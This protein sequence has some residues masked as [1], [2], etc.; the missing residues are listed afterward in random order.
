MFKY[1]C[2]LMCTTENSVE[3]GKTLKINKQQCRVVWMPG[4]GITPSQC[5]GK[6]TAICQGCLLFVSCPS[7]PGDMCQQC[8]GCAVLRGSLRPLAPG[9]A[10]QVGSGSALGWAHCVLT[11]AAAFP[12]LLCWAI[13]SQRHVPLMFPPAAACICTCCSCG[14][15]VKSSCS[16]LSLSLV[17]Q[18]G[19]SCS[20]CLE[21]SGARAALSCG[22]GCKGKVQHI[23]GCSG[24]RESLSLFSLG[25]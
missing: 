5:V 20:P 16:R 1:M 19:T 6:W 3:G 8:Q 22:H 18:P 9:D 2:V 15:A 11:A 4:W 7:C 13:L 21:L 10:E 23:F 17:L 12:S 25:N 24:G 14:H